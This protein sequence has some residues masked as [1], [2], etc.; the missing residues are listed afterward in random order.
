M[1]VNVDLALFKNNGLLIKRWTMTEMEVFRTDDIN[2]EDYNK[3]D[4]LSRVSARMARKFTSIL[5]LDY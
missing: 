4:A 2:A 1:T 5:L 3:R